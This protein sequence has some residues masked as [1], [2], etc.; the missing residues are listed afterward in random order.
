[1]PPGHDS[2]TS[3]CVVTVTLDL[4][5]GITGS[6]H[7]PVGSNGARWGVEVASGGARAFEGP[8]HELA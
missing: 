5:T 1:M 3:V 6:G 2:V 4:F 7:C 8:M